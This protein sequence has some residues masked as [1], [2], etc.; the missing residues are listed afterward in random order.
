M[1]RFGESDKETG[2]VLWLH[3]WGVAAVF[4]VVRS[5]LNMVWVHAAPA[6]AAVTHTYFSHLGAFFRPDGSA[7][8]CWSRQASLNIERLNEILI[9]AHF[10]WLV[11]KHHQTWVLL[12]W[13]VAQDVCSPPKDWKCLTSSH[14]VLLPCHMPRPEMMSPYILPTHCI[15][16]RKSILHSGSTGVGIL[17][18]DRYVDPETILWKQAPVKTISPV[19]RAR[20][21]GSR[22][23][24]FQG[25]DF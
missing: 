5:S 1:R 11:F 21:D 22:Q 9:L 25:A 3:V 24:A 13:K 19:E 2:S 17:E 14:I 8:N 18:V 6:P 16:W 23:S 4:V 12:E 20:A 15:M 7:W 10:T